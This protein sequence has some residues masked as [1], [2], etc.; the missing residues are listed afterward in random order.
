ML[1]TLLWMSDGVL[2]TPLIFKVGGKGGVGQG[3]GGGLSNF[4]N[5][6][7]NDIFKRTIK[8]GYF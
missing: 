7:I 5:I 8:T 6:S 4:S 2:I 3:G 1:K